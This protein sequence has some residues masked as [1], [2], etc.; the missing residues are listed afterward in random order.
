MTL[1]KNTDNGKSCFPQTL[2]L[3]SAVAVNFR[4]LCSTDGLPTVRSR[5]LTFVRSLQVILP[6]G[7]FLNTLYGFNSSNPVALVSFWN[8]SRNWDH[9]K[10]NFR[11]SLA[12]FPSCAGLKLPHFE[13]RLKSALLTA[14][15]HALLSDCVNRAFCMSAMTNNNCQKQGDFHFGSRTDRVFWGFGVVKACHLHQVF[16]Y[17]FMF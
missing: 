1:C 13:R 4:T 7:L 9:V 16:I 12:V 14:P 11:A 10:W 3:L 5:F 17:S 2:C 8:Y 15:G 6:G